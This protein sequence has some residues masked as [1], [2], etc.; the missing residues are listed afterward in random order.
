MEQK[1]K[2]TLA[3]TQAG[4]HVHTHTHT[5][6]LLMIYLRGWTQSLRVKA[7]TNVQT[8]KTKSHKHVQKK[9]HNSRNIKR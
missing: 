4:T 8:C 2:K 7:D 9:E 3:H 6:A 1:T 5:R